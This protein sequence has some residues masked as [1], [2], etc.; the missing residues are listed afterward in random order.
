[1][2]ETLTTLFETKTTGGLITELKELLNFQQG[3]EEDPIDY[4]V[5]ATNKWANFAFKDI[6]FSVLSVIVPLWGLSDKFSSV[7]ER[8]GNEDPSKLNAKDI[9]SSLQ[10]AHSSNIGVQ[11]FSVKK[12]A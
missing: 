4:W 12:E 9:M 5:R 8:F 6:N 3:D 10:M 2:W 7:R 11:G 1:M